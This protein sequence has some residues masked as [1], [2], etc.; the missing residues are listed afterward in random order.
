MEEY[1]QFAKQL[2]GKA[3]KIIIDN[4]DQEYEIEIKSDNS[5]VTKIDKQINA[6]VAKAIA[7]T[8]PEHG[9]LGE[10][11][12]SGTGKEKYQWLCDPID[13]TKAFILGIPN[14]VF[15][16][17]LTENGQVLM[18][19]IYNPFTDKMYHAIKAQGAFCNDRQIHVNNHK[20]NGGYVL[21]EASSFPYLAKI[22]Q[23]GGV[24]EPVPGTGYKAMLLAQGKGVG[25]IKGDADYHDIGP[26]SLIVEEAGGRVTAL[27]GSVLRYDREIPGVILSNGVCH[28]DLL[29]IVAETHEVENIP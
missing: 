4:F 10:E 21:L 16:L 24:E 28:A 26:S 7:E 23:A 1:L 13:G 18:S 5:P 27:D 29:K 14:S 11:E 2:A 12:N 19:V 22:S 17:A 8:Y 9:L 6:T 20:I 3:G 15:M 25:I